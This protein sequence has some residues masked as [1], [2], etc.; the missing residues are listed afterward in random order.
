MHLP[1]PCWT[2]V[3][4]PSPSPDVGCRCHAIVPAYEGD[5]LRQPPRIPGSYPH[6]RDGSAAGPTLPSREQR[7]RVHARMCSELESEQ[8]RARQLASS[9]F[10][11]VRHVD[12]AC[13]MKLSGS[14]VGVCISVPG[15]STMKSRSSMAVHG[16]EMSAFSSEQGI[17]DEPFIGSRTKSRDRRHGLRLTH[18]NAVHVDTA[19]HIACKDH[20]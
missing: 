19:N 4:S 3:F 14:A 9:P 15:N 1:L 10:S 17:A 20:L 18:T 13:A 6:P 11:C 16:N 8:A 2:S 7:L 12:S 5:P